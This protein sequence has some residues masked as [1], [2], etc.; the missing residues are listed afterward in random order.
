MLSSSGINSIPNRLMQHAKRMPC[1]CIHQ[2]ESVLPQT[3]WRPLAQPAEQTCAALQSLRSPRASARRCGLVLSSWPAVSSSPNVQYSAVNGCM[4]DWH[5]IH[6]GHRSR[7]GAA[8]LT[9]EATAV[10]P[11]GRIT[12]ADV[13]LWNDA[14]E[15]AIGRALESIRRWPDMPIAIQLAHAGRKASTEVPWKGGA[16]LPRRHSDF[17]LRTLPVV[18]NN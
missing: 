11:E 4:T 10:L 5:L 18:T 13:G 1:T 7:S 2:C 16:Q 3:K 8:L 6:L 14:T 17:L 9:I 15:A 12:Y